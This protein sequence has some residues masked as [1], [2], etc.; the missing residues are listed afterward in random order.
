MKKKFFTLLLA[1]L[2]VLSFY[3]QNSGLVADK[4]DIINFSSFPYTPLLVESGAED[5]Y[6]IGSSY[7]G[8]SVNHDMLNEL[9]SDFSNI[10]FIKYDKDLN[11]L[12]SAYIVGSYTT[13][14]V[15]TFEGGLTVFGDAVTNVE[16]NGNVL[17]LNSADR[18]EYIVKYNDLC[19]FERL[20]SIWDL[21]PS[22]Y[23]YS[24]SMM[25]PNTGTLYI[26][27]RASQPYNLLT[28]G[29]IGKDMS[30]YLYVLSYDRSLS[31]TGVFIA[32]MEEGGESGYYK[33]IE[34]IPDG[35]GNVIIT[36]GWEGDQSPVIDGEILGD[37]IENEGVFAVKLDID[38]KKEWVIKGNLN[39]FDYDG[40]SGITKGLALGNGDLIM[41]GATATGHFSLGDL[42]IV[43]AD[44][45]GYTNMFAFRISS[46]GKVQW[47]RPIQNMLDA[48]GGKKG[49][50]SE[51]FTSIIDM[52]IVKWKEE[53]LYLCGRFRGV[54]LEVAGKFLE[55]ELGEGAFV[56]AL[57]MKTGLD[58]W[59]YSLSSTFTE[60]CGFDVDGS[61]N[62]ALLGKTGNDQQFQGL[63]ANTG[64]SEMVFHLGL[65]YKGIPLWLNNAILDPGG[66][67][68]YGSDL[69]VLKNGEVFSSMYKNVI[70][71]LII[72]GVTIYSKDPYSSILVKLGA[73]TQLG[74]TIYDK[75]GTTVYPGIVKAF[76]ATS[77]GAYPLVQTVDIDDSGRYMFEGLYPGSYRLLAIPDLNYYPDGMPTYA[78]GAISWEGAQNLNIRS[79]E[80]TSL[81]DISLSELPKLT[82]SDGS[83]QLSG[84]VS[85]ADDFIAKSTLARPAKKTAV[86]LRSKASSKGTSED[87][88]VVAYLDTDEEGNYIF[89]Y[90][91]DG[92]YEMLVDVPGLPMNGNYDVNVVDNT[93]VSELD[94]IIETEGIAIPGTTGFKLEEVDGLMI[95][96]NP[97]NG[98][99]HIELENQGDYVVQ[100]F[101]TVGMLV[102]QR[103]FYAVAGLVDLDLSSLKTGMYLVKIK[104]EKLT[105]AVKYLKNRK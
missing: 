58:R 42:K 11:P 28:H 19:Q 94:F 104:G 97:G 101:N 99:M 23:P 13:P 91:P 83:G 35:T 4:S 6:W 82:A 33:N 50:K 70:D 49:A 10:Y 2:S 48:Y 7:Q 54:Q 41:L 73:N 92:T 51:E 46:E 18:L 95:Y 53:V 45:D 47:E 67:S 87:E 16:A 64:E 17:P 77:K 22:Q 31:L 44:G 29:I 26:A 60:L 8:T 78:G 12:G 30:E 100:V 74:G 71:P 20:V 14:D 76:K 52:D 86:I 27:G 1:F 56:A 85:Y 59:G 79:S 24:T 21:D 32:G 72:G 34:I 66:Y 15:F 88:D 102:D 96:P 36:G 93:I 63:G 62:V 9:S 80:R 68:L 105:T 39:G 103:E 55:N 37:E 43:F 3:G 81:L 65:D 98:F 69:E 25:D 40:S 61:G 75:S 90:V 84:N 57:D 38:L 89:E 5:F